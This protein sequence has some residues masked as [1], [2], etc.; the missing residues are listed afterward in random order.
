MLQCT[1][2]IGA[3]NSCQLVINKFTTFLVANK[4]SSL[5]CTISCFS[6]QFGRWQH[7]CGRSLL[8]TIALSIVVFSDIVPSYIASFFEINTFSVLRQKGEPVYSSPLHTSGL[9]WQLKVYLVG[10]VFHFMYFV[11]F[12]LV[13][14]CCCLD[15]RNNVHLV[16]GLNATCSTTSLLERRQHWWSCGS[17]HVKFAL[18][19]C[20]TVLLYNEK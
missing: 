5:Q 6:I 9:A 1:Q 10:S 2:F 14:S 8:Y 7:D 16:N 13:L 20:L 11:V 4:L 15:N 12:S 3:Y 17:L 19:Y 18:I